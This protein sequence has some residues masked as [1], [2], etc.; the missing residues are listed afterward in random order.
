MSQTKFIGIVSLATA[1]V[2]G[3]LGALAAGIPSPAQSI[4]STGDEGALALLERNAAAGDHVAQFQL[5]QKY[6][7]G[8]GTTQNYAKAAQW[9]Q[10]AAA[11]G[12]PVAQTDLGWLYYQGQG[13][14]QDYRQAAAWWRKGAEAGNAKAQ[15]GLAW[16]YATGQGVGRHNVT[17]AKWAIVAKAGG[18]DRASGVLQYVE[19]QMSRG[20]IREAQR[21]ADSWWAA[22]R[23]D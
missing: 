3:S 4:G 22:H 21:Q 7:F 19:S 16:L 17:A 20:Q 9:W 10:K 12:D 11:S 23:A 1:L 5:G 8:Q 6:A 2:L 14:P 13:V 18:F 15:G